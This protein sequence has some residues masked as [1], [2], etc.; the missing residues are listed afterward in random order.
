MDLD[1]AMAELTEERLRHR[2]GYRW[3]EHPADVLPAFVADMDLPLAEPITAVLAAMVADGDVGYAPR[4]HATRL[5]GLVAQWYARRG[6]FVDPA[7]V[8]MVPDVVAAAELVLSELCSPGDGVVISTPLYGPLRRMAG[9][10]GRVAVDVPLLLEDGRY[11]LDLDGIGAALADGARVVLLC[12]PQNPTGTVLTAAEMAGVVALVQEHGAWLV[13][14]EIHAPLVLDVEHVSALAAGLPADRTVVVT[15]TSKGWNTAGLKCAVTIAGSPELAARFGDAVVSRRGGIGILGVA[16]MEAALEH[17]EP[18]RANA[19]EYLRQRRDQ[20]LARLSADVPHAVAGRPQASYLAW[21]DLR[22]YGFDRTS[23]PVATDWLL[24]HARVALSPGRFFGDD[25]ERTH[26]RLNYATTPVIID[27][28]M[29]RLAEA[30]A[31]RSP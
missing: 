17:G 25:Y 4:L 19:C 9:E 2:R 18:W 3:S 12:Q 21:I 24:E 27:Q 22:A 1:A 26:V 15:S 7:C 23:G 13:C 16:A 31:R 14:D 28:I 10:E 8:D 5:P 6:S 29:D 30:L 11:R 20:V